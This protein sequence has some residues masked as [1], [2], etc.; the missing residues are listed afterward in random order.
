MKVHPCG[1]LV[2]IVMGQVPGQITAITIRF[3]VVL[4]EITYLF[5]GVYQ[6]VNLQDCEF[7]CEAKKE[8]IGYK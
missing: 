2:K 8:K 7:L 6:T 1:S 5:D 4:Y 3:D